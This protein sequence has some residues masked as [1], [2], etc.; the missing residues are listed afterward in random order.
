LRSQIRAGNAIGIDQWGAWASW[1]GF[2]VALLIVITRVG[3]ILTG[4]PDGWIT[5][6]WGTAAHWAEQIVFLLVGCFMALLFGEALTYRYRRRPPL[7]S[8]EGK[9]S[10]EQ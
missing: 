5:A 1:L 4:K 10:K 2:F 7:S 9:R 6:D 8:G 3:G